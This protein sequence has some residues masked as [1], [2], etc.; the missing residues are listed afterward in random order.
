M[1]TTIKDTFNKVKAAL[2]T[3]GTNLKDRINPQGKTARLIAIYQPKDDKANIEKL[4]AEAKALGLSVTKT[5]EKIKHLEAEVKKEAQETKGLM[6][7]WVELNDDEYPF[8]VD[9]KSYKGTERLKYLREVDQSY[10]NRIEEI[11]KS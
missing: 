7:I 5:G 8:I 11:A 4:E 2:V 1:F 6:G 3:D 10:A 9:E